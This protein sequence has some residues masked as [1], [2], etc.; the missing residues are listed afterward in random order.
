MDMYHDRDQAP[1]IKTLV[2]RLGD[3]MYRQKQVR[4]ALVNIGR[5]A[6]PTLISA[7]DSPN[8]RK[9]WEAILV[10]GQIKDPAAAESLIRH[11][12]DEDDDVRYAAMES[13][14]ALRRGAVKPILQALT[15]RFRSVRIMQGAHHIFRELMHHGLLT[16]QEIEVLNALEDSAP[17]MR[18]PWM[19]EAALEELKY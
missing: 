6:V 7:L 5:D 9:R 2:E 16:E 3:P 11:L 4:Q 18:V 1:D 14:I 17:D 19:A 10:L 8:S 13:L 15:D 12:E